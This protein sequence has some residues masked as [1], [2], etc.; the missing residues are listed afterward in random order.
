MERADSINGLLDKLNYDIV[1]IQ[2]QKQ[3]KYVLYKKDNILN[4]KIITKTT[5]TDLIDDLVYYFNQIQPNWY[6]DI[7][8]GKNPTYNKGKKLV[9]EFLSDSVSRVNDIT[10][11]PAESLFFTD[12][13]TSIS[14]FNLFQNTYYLVERPNQEKKWD[15]IN[16]ILWNLCEK[17]PEY[18]DWVINWLAVLYQYPTYRFT[19]SIIFIGAKGSGKGM[20]TKVM[21]KIFGHCCYAANSKDLISNFYS[22]IFENKLLLIANEIIDQNKKYQFSNDLKEMI[23]ED[24]ISVERKFT[25]RYEAKNY[26][27]TI[28]FS[29]SNMPIVIEE[30]DRRYAVFKSQK[31]KM[32]YK[33]R[34]KFFEDEE[35]FTNQVEGFMAYLNNYIIDQEKVV[36]EPI[37]TPAKESIIHV[38]T[39]DLKAIINEIIEEQNNDWVMDNTNGDYWISYN[40]IYDIYTQVKMENKK[41]PA[42]N[43]FSHK[44]KVNDFT[45]EKRTIDSVTDTYVKVPFKLC[46]VND[47]DEEE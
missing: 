16:N 10:N 18:Y 21:Q 36:S 1:K 39:T 11:D 45:V 5:K 24:K 6:V 44:L 41:R 19:T 9:D 40:V 4:Y 47:D 32:D 13:E 8:G 12:K 25:D 37:M 46:N 26:V 30:G 43:K 33:V 42:R 3:H 2:S 22:Q 28:F 23:T 20:F 34:N 38:N 35:F 29:N 14:Y 15:V 7:V 27:K 31:L 17:N